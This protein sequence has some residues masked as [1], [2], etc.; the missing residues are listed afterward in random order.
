MLLE[1]HPYFVAYMVSIYAVI[2]TLSELHCLAASGDA[3]IVYA[4]DQSLNG[5]AIMVKLA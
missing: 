5:L 2:F 3:Y 4:S 1:L